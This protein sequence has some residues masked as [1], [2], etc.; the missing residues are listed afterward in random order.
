[1]FIERAR[2]VR[3]Y[4]RENSPFAS[5]YSLFH[6]ARNSTAMER[7]AAFLKF[8]DIVWAIELDNPTKKAV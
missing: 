1:M 5:V 3:C 2:A 8:N 6:L 7:G 4:L